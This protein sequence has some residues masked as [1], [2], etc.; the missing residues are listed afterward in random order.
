MF[1]N[2]GEKLKILAKILFVLNVIAFIVLAIVFGWEKETVSG[3]GSYGRLYSDYETV[4]YPGRFFP[5]IIGGPLV[6]YF[7][8]LIIYAFG[9]L[10]D[11][12]EKTNRNLKDFIDWNKTSTVDAE[13][14][15]LASKERKSHVTCPSCGEEN[16]GDQMFCFKCGTRL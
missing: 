12:T 9:E 14:D 3:W 1:E 16:P 8:C 4:F 10:V 6:S 2:S 13:S 15:R 11:N 7:E 5:F